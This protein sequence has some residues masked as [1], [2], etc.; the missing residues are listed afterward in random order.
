MAAVQSKQFF[1]WR[2]PLPPLDEQKLIAHQLDS[3]DRLVSD[4]S[5]GLPSELAAR[6]KQYEFYRD[7]LLSFE[8]LS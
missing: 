7:R 8:E 5:I 3:F 4:L 2:I 1:D 6:R